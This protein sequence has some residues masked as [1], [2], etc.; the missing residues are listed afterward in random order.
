MKS[1]NENDPIE[2][3][4]GRKVKFVKLAIDALD[5]VCDGCVFDGCGHCPNYI[6]GTC[7]DHDGIP[8]N[9]GIFLEVESME[10]K[11]IISRITAVDYDGSK[12]S[13]PVKETADNLEVLRRHLKELYNAERVY[14][15]YEQKEV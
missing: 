10:P 3:P 7:I 14:F 6:T 11:F 12:R 13:F 1:N 15:T 4:D 8:G 5:E 2:L 9:N